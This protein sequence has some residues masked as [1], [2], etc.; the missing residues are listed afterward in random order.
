VATAAEDRLTFRHMHI[1]NLA[2]DRERRVTPIILVAHVPDVHEEITLALAGNKT[3]STL[4]TKKFHFAFENFRHRFSP[5]LS[6]PARPP[7]GRA[8]VTLDPAP[9]RMLLHFRRCSEA[10]AAQRG[11]RYGLE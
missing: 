7:W 3:E 11:S 5:F 10:S 1:F 4:V 6:I 9:L 8:S 2:T